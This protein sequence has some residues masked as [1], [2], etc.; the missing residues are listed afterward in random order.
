MSSTPIPIASTGEV[1]AIELEKALSSIVEELGRHRQIDG[2]LP[3]AETYLA[4]STVEVVEKLG[5]AA[6]KAAGKRNGATAVDQ[7]DVASG[8]E[9]V[10]GRNKELKA[11]LLCI[12]GILAGAAS[13][14]AAGV[15]L[16][17][18]IGYDWVWWVVI[19]VLTVAALAMFF[20]AKPRKS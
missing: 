7:C 2:F 16:T 18:P 12:A 15:L 3:A 17:P 11:W 8:Y 9:Q 5:V 10:T 13:S 4:A 6:V 1:S 20:Y 14:C 19:G